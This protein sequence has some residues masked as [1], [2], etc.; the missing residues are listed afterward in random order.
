MLA[1][2]LSDG[3]ALLLCALS[4]GAGRMAHLEA[5]A[6]PGCH[7]AP[8]RDSHAWFMLTGKHAVDCLRKLCG[9]DLSLHKFSDHALA[10]P[11]VPRLFALVIRHGRA[12]QAAVP[13]P[14]D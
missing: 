5:A 10:T 2:R 7:P 6:G 13:L 12:G 14:G 11:L 3:E 1:V 9:V 4:G 8:R